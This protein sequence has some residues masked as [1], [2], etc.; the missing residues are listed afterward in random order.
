[1]TIGRSQP[2]HQHSF[3]S[4][5]DELRSTPDYTSCEEHD[6]E[7]GIN[8]QT[9]FKFK[10]FF[11]FFLQIPSCSDNIQVNRSVDALP[12]IFPLAIYYPYFSFR[13]NWKW[14]G[15]KLPEILIYFFLLYIFLY[16]LSKENNKIYYSKEITL[17]K[18]VQVI[19]ENPHREA[20]TGIISKP[21]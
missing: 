9:P 5:D 21:S 8:N 10:I 16:I 4:S 14:K 6:S 2:Q 12:T 20:M 11:W 15:V 18:Y 3:S 1:M 13:F 17:Y 19:S 7:K